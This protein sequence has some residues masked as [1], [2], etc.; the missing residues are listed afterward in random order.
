MGVFSA[1]FGTKSCE[2]CDLVQNLSAFSVW[3]GSDAQAAGAQ[4]AFA[5][6]LR[7]KYRE[8]VKLGQNMHTSSRQ[9]PSL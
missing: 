7:P 8:I 6:R 4:T 5:V 2:S 3:E 9:D 1:N